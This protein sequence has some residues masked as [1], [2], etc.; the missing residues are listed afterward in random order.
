[1]PLF[2]KDTGPIYKEFE[3]LESIMRDLDISITGAHLSINY[4]GKLYRIGR[5]SDTFP[6]EIEEHFYL[7]EPRQ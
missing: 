5:D 4:K 6:R 2:L 3:K 1:M 7:R